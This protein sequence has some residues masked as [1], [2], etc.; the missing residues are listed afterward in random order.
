MVIELLYNKLVAE[1]AK[2]LAEVAKQK[3]IH[4]MIVVVGV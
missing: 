3:G 1:V 4:L 2:M